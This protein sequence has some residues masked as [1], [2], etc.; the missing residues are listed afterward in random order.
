MTDKGGGQSEKRPRLLKAM[1]DLVRLRRNS[2]A[3]FRP[4][5]FAG[6]CGSGHSPD[7][8]IREIALLL[9]LAMNQ[10]GQLK[11]ADL[12]ETFTHASGPGGQNVNKVA[13]KVTLRHV[14]SG[15]SVTAQDSRSQARNREVARERLAA[16][17]KQKETQRRASLRHTRE[18]AR[19][20]NRPR[21]AGVKRRIR[22]SKT[23][24]AELKSRRAKIRP[25]DH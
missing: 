25:S 17:L 22:E 12:E 2:S 5:S 8:Q 23:R 20:R 14:P 13:T 7:W 9:S 3:S 21:P 10:N 6:V 15:L 18:K 16:L 24:R 4:P 11:E 19:R 1:S